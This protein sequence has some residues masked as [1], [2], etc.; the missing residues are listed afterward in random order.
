MHTRFN[1]RLSRARRIIEHA[2]GIL[3]SR[4]RIF[5]S[6]IILRTDKI[7]QVE[8]AATLLRKCLH[9]HCGAQYVPPSSID[10]QD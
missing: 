2:F 1:Y 8:L 10:V 9:Q 3:A 4:F 7:E 6:H 5:R